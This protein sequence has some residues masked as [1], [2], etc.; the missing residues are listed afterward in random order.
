[1][2]RAIAGILAGAQDK[3][4][5][6]NLDAKR[7]WGFAPEYVE[8]QWRILQ[9]D[10]P[11]DYVIGMGES[12][13]VREFV[14]KAFGYVGL[15]WQDHVAIA[16]RYLRPTEVDHLQADCS[17][18]RERLGWDPKVGFEQ[19]VQIMVDADME[20]LG[21]EPPG[22]GRAS[23]LEAGFD[24]MGMGTADSIAR[25]RDSADQ[26]E[27]GMLTGRTVFRARKSAETAEAEA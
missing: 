25:A 9:E 15:D 1:V 13:S 19:L 26:W 20:A 11:G 5:L 17:R 2:T 21:L 8:F 14:E 23:L 16:S 12:H 4:F 10:E 18:A 7:D 6:G 3:L 22:K 27:D 24:W